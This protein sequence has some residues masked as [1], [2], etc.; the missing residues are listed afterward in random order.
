MFWVGLMGGFSI[1]VFGDRTGNRHEMA[2]ESVSRCNVGRFMERVSSR[3]RWQRSR[4]QLWPKTDP[5]PKL[6]SRF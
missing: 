1:L 2:S 5:K 3:G 6:K 4:A